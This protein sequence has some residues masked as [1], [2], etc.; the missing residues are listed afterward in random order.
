MRENMKKIILLLLCLL[1]LLQSATAATNLSEQSEIDKEE[2]FAALFEADI[3]SVREALDLGLISC[4]EL[5]AY[6]LERIEAYNDTFQCFITLCDDALQIAEQRDEAIANGTAGGLLFGIPVVIKDNMDYTGYPTTNGLNNRNAKVKE[7]A[8]VVQYLLDEGAVILGKTNMSAGAQDAVCSMNEAGLQTF[9]AY[10]PALSSGGSSGGSAVA[11]SLNFAVAGLG[12]DTNSSLRYPSALNGCVSLR[13]TFG[14]IDRN[15]C[16]PLNPDRDTIGAITRTVMDQAIMLDVLT[17]G[18]Y[19]FADNLDPHIL[20]GMRIGILAEFSYP[21]KN[22]GD[23]EA[24][25]LDDEIEAAFANSVAELRACGAEVVDISV[26]NIFSYYKN[27]TDLD[28]KLEKIFADNNISA[29]IY[30]AYLHTPHYVAKEFLDGKGVY[31]QPYISNCNSLSSRAG[32][33]EITVP[34]GRHS[35]GAGIGLE[36]LSLK[37]ND[38]LLLNI[39]YSYL[40]NYSHRQPSELAPS[41]YDGSFRLSRYIENYKQSI[42]DA[43][44]E[45]PQPLPATTAPTLPEPSDELAE[46]VLLPPSPPQSEALKWYY[47]IAPVMAIALCATAYVAWKFKHKSPVKK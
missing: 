37:N 20:Q 39:A 26:P 29:L 22:S 21:V 44:K 12:S 11:V 15:G 9:N 6:Y 41:L 28:K 10:N 47:I 46:E 14:L 18:E 17:A 13:P 30:P 4:R 5:T 23:R 2:L 24:S 38:Q 34:I 16:V 40:S 32:M 27:T 35:R 31:T 25:D 19:S 7:N 36:I 45:P 8:T 1:F 3:L 43:Q 42:E 33:P